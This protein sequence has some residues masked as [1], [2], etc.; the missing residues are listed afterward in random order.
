MVLLHFASIS[1]SKFEGVSVVV[2]KHIEEQAFEGHDVALLNIR[3]IKIQGDIQQFKYIKPFN[4]QSLPEPFNHPDLVIFQECY[5]KEYIQL[6]KQL[7]KAGIK[8]IIIPHGEL[9]SE[10]QRKKYLKKKLANILFF[11]RFINGAVGIQCLSKRELDNTSFG[12]YKFIGTNGVSIPRKTKEKFSEGFNFLYIGRLDAYHK[13]LDLLVEAVK[14]TQ[15]LLRQKNAV[16]TI[17]GPDIK[18]R[19]AYLKQLIDEAKVDDLIML[20]HEIVGDEK[21]E[22]LLCSD[23]FI[24]TSRFEGMPLGILEA[25]SFGIPCLV[26]RGTTLGTEIENSNSGW[27]AE[28]SSDSIANTIVKALGEKDNLNEYSSNAIRLV[29][30]KYAWKVVEKQAIEEYK[31]LIND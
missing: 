8:Y 25:L 20:N 10:A 2:P 6:G 15:T 24:Q 23:I 7:R 3:N 9:N 16:F 19:Y 12:R 22:A 28:T 14:E 11:N 4:I 26:T 18:G 1:N 17:Y 29:S 31:R 13:G 30:E 5:V 27:M 21:V